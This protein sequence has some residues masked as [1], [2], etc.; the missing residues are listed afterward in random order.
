MASRGEMVS[1][2][3]RQPGVAEIGRPIERAVRTDRSSAEEGV[4][5]VQVEQ[6]R[7]LVCD[8]HEVYRLGLRA[9]L[10]GVGD[11][12]LVGETTDPGRALMLAF[13]TSPH[14][15]LVG[16]QLD[17]G[18]T[19]DLI[20]RLGPAETGV[21]V[22]AD[23]DDEEDLIEALRAGARGYLG[24]WVTPDRLLDGIRAVARRETAL[25]SSVAGHL[26]RYLH[27]RSK[28]EERSGRRRAVAVDM[29]IVEGLTPR[30]LEVAR[31]V[32]DGLSNAEVAARLY[33]SEATVKSHLTVILKRL[34]LRDRTQLAILV[35]RSTWADASHAGPEPTPRHAEGGGP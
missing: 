5:A 20:R 19:V 23:S 28:G 15:V 26:L 2:L 7:V 6:L 21:I 4:R 16:R 1:H 14:V 30:Q 3:R 27:D 8:R 17:R 13:D 24:R 32:A 33:V 18:G 29:A 25:D 22:L 31:L 12:V 11:M 9:V 10:S 35:N 34:S